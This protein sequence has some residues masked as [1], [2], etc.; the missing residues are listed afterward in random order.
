V[1]SVI[2]SAL[3]SPT[4]SDWAGVRDQ[5]GGWDWSVSFGG[6]AMKRGVGLFGLISNINNINSVV[7]NL[8]TAPL[9]CTHRN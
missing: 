6:G 5:H 9:K 2:D 3:A 8:L 1:F 7:Q 4:N